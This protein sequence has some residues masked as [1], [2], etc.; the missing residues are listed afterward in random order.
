MTFDTNNPT[1]IRSLRAITGIAEPM[2][3]GFDTRPLTGELFALGYDATT[4]LRRR[5]G[6][7]H[8]TPVIAMTAGVTDGQ[9]ERCLAAGMDD[10][11]SKPVTPVS[12]DEALTRWVMAP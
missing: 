12:L 11:V 5:E 3:A 6:R 1:F 4:E 10:Y 9:R 2:I 7:G 8:R